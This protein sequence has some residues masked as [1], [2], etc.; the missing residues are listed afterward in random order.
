MYR[1]LRYAVWVIVRAANV[2]VD[3]WRIPKGVSRS[4]CSP[5]GFHF[6]AKTD[7]TVWGHLRTPDRT[8]NFGR[9]G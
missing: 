8:T 2:E 9:Q 6:G 3:R 7:L 5:R 4:W 1:G